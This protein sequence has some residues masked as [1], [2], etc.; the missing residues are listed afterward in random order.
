MIKCKILSIYLIVG[1][2][3]MGFSIL[4]NQPLI[5]SASAA[6]D[7]GIDGYQ[8]LHEDWIVTG[9]EE[10]TDEIIAL[11]GDLTIENGGHLI[12]YNCTLM[13]MSQYL[14]PYEIIVEGGG[15]LE[16]YDGYV[17]D[18]PGDDD[19][20]LLSAYYY[21]VAREGSTLIIEDSTVRQHGFI[22]LAN[23]EHLGLSISTN[24]G[25]ITNSIIN[26][27]VIGLA[28]FGNNSGFYVENSNISQIAMT[29]I[30]LNQAEGVII[31]NISFSETGESNVVDAQSSSNF[32][33]E[34]INLEGEQFIQAEYSFG[35]E[36]RNIVS[37]NPERVLEIN[38]CDNFKVLGVDIVD[39]QDWNRRISVERSTNFTFDDISDND[40]TNVMFFGECSY[41]TISNLTGSNI[42]WMID[43]EK[44]D[45]ITVKDVNVGGNEYVIRFSDSK[46]ITMDR[47]NI[48]GGMFPIYF[49]TVNESSISN[50]IISDFSDAG[51]S[52]RDYSSNVS[53]TDA[54]IETSSI[55]FT[56]GIL[57][58]YGFD[59]YV[60]NLETHNLNI[61]L[62]CRYGSVFAED[63]IIDG[64]LEQKYG[65][66][67]TAVEESLLSNISIINKVQYGF[68]L[69]NC[70]DDTPILNNVYVKDST[71][72][73]YLWRSNISIDKIKI[74]SATDDV[75]ADIG[76][77]ATIMNSTVNSLRLD[78]SDII[79]INTTNTTAATFSGI[80]Q[81]IIK[82]W[83][84]VFVNDKAGPVVGALVYVI[85]GSFMEDAMG[86]TG[87][88]GFVR[89][90]AATEVI[91]TFGPTADNKN[92]HKTEASGPGWLADNLTFYQVDRNMRV[93]V[94]YGGDA[95][96]FEATNIQARSDE[97]SN[98]ILTWDPS[99]SQD[100]IG[101]N[102]YFA[103]NF[104]D[105]W[106]YVDF[107]T[108]NG[109][110]AGTTYTHL[111]G[112]ANWD[113]F[114]Y[115]VLSYDNENMTQFRDV[116]MCGDWVVN[117]SSPQS[118]GNMNINMNGSLIIYGDL[119]LTNINLFFYSDFN[120]FYGIYIHN[121][122]SINIDNLTVDRKFINFPYYF[123]INSDAEVFINNSEFI[124]P[125][126]DEY[127]DDWANIGIYS[128]TK[129]LTITNTKIDVQYAG[130]GIY[131]VLDFQ[132]LIYNVS[133]TT[134]FA[135]EQP[136][137][138][139][140]VMDSDNL[141]IS[142]CS[143]EGTALY[144]IYVGS[145]TNITITQNKIQMHSFNQGPAW[146][147]YFIY[148]G[149]S[150][151]YD[152]PLL[153]GISP[154]YILFS[155]DITV[156]NSNISGHSLYGIHAE[157]SWYTTITECYF[158][159]N[160]RPDIGIYMSWC[161]ESTVRDMESTE[162][163][164]FLIMENE[165][166]AT[167]ENLSITSGDLAITIINSEF[168]LM[169]DVYI[170]FIQN[171]MQIIGGHE[172]TLKNVE[173]NLTLNGLQVKSAGPIYLITSTLANCISGELFAEGYQG[174]ASNLILENSTIA[175]IGDF[176][177]ILNNTAVVHLLNT[178]F[179]LTKLKIED[180][181][182]RLEIFHYLSVQVYDIDNNIPTA[183]D[184]TIMNAKDDIVYDETVLSGYA[185]WILIHEKTVFRDDTYI[186]NPHNIYVF[187][188]SHFG[189]REVYINYSQHI[190]V[191][192][193][194]QFPIITLMGIYGFYDNPFPIPDDFTLFPTTKYD[195][196]LNY[197]YEDPEGDPESGT[198][199]HWYINGIYNSSFDGMTTISPQ[200]TQKG[201]LWQ[202]YV[203]PSDG[204]DSTYPTFAFESNIV[205]ILNTPPSVSNV[206]ITP[207]DPT[208]GDDLFVSFDVFD[209]DDDGLDSSKTTSRWYRYHPING[210]EYS[211]IDSF[212]LPSQYT[213]KGEIWRCIVIPH[214]GDEAGAFALSQNVTIGNTPPS[215]QNA[216]ITAET[217]DV[218]ITGA[219]NLKAQYFFFDSD[220]D[221]ENG[222]AYQWEYQRDGGPWTDVSVN[223][224]VLPFTYTTRGDLW[225]CTIF[226]KDDDDFGDGV[227]TEAMEILNTP[228]MISNV[229]I[230][231]QFATS[232]D[233]LEVIYDYFDYDGDSENGT[234]FRW[235]YEDALGSK[236]SG[237][238][239]NVTPY[240]AVVKQQTW[241]C[242]VIPSDGINVG[243]ELRSDGVLIHNT[244]PTIDEAYMDI[245]ITDIDMHLAINYNA[246]DIDEDVIGSPKIR[247]YKNDDAQ[248][249]FD[250]NQTVPENNL[251]KG[252][253]WYV[254]ISVFDGEDW[255]GNY[256]T[257]STQ[258][259]NTAPFI[260]GTPTLSPSQALSNQNLQPIFED[261]Y[262]DEDGDPLTD[263]EIKWYRDNGHLEDYDDY[264]EISWDL[265]NKGEIWY[266]KV[267]VSDGE[268]SSDWYSSTTTIIKNSP[269]SNITQSP[270]ETEVTI[271]ETETR[272][273]NVS[274][275]DIDRDPLS[276]R[277]TLDGRIVLLDEG[278][279][280]S[281]Y[282][283][284]TD[285]D[286]E[287][288]YI[289]R[290][291]I[292]DGDDSGEITWT[293]N[294]EKMNRL[295]EIAVVEP[296]GRSAS[297]KE[298]EDLRFA[299]TK[300]DSDGDNLDVL[301]YIDGVLVWEGSDKYTYSP[302]YASSGSHT[303]T[304]EVKE[305]E[306]GAN[307]T[308]SWDVEVADVG[309]AMDTFLG[310]N[311][312]L[313]SIMLEII[314]IGGTGLL[315][316]IGYRRIRKKKGALKIYMA[317]IEE[318]SVQKEENPQE[319]EEKLSDIEAKIN[320]E[321]SQGKIEDLHFLMLQE[322]IAGHRGGI[323][324]AAIT[325]KFGGLPEGILKE[326][327]EMLK[328]GK[329]S[330]EEYDG[331][332][333]TI[334]K[335][336]SL[337]SEEK[338][339]L[340]KIIGEW[341]VEDKDLSEEDTPDEKVEPKETKEGKEQD[342][343]SSNEYE[344]E[345]S[346]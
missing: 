55:E 36:V 134:E 72:G 342:V 198:I 132:G 286:S 69:M 269:P 140:S 90:L 50:L 10:Y 30:M 285:Y 62:T 160:D 139:I 303:I 151:I 77:T 26:S 148:C 28:F 9:Y 251:T 29:A 58:D 323:R 91:W 218:I 193:S 82:W 31:N 125:G 278:V 123:K 191:Q 315:A 15:I 14:Q 338:E 52:I 201:Q 252:D 234:S 168:I 68:Y 272:E 96:P 264:D 195:V 120:G 48:A 49:D 65:I 241:Y 226:P 60:R 326:L 21:F 209:L 196:V 93:N 105:L 44:S 266:Y 88:D 79:C 331:F 190:D 18:I 129:N 43:S 154:I 176:S 318:V 333:G 5:D 208:G 66:K 185:K 171:G 84:D 336:K 183:A 75:W 293:V 122:G 89:N 130:L 239:G 17:T 279:E 268:D 200:Y 228:P 302:D 42:T 53:V 199:I 312:D 245:I 311:W 260:N 24:S 219:D 261:L 301:W 41:G 231:P 145:S 51:V 257:V 63:I 215:I 317:E 244:A 267:R 83:V 295:P 166:V 163:N 19:T 113:R 255:S 313:W 288:D 220:G 38:D 56:K 207:S 97:M 35:F 173:I 341:E 109:T 3:L 211:S 4:S 230:Q 118:A 141:T 254:I 78:S 119:Q 32:I 237:I 147:I 149:N 186:D 25:H 7:D 184:I 276:Y 64:T 320:D 214:D 46:H 212:Y 1:M 112:S 283:F 306:S 110:V 314:V 155:F 227:L 81:L 339:E 116:V 92:P 238:H 127:S 277:W 94:T 159:T 59:V 162:V 71:Y 102:I 170:T 213:T 248:S 100:V 296:E 203:Y 309:E 8:E 101:Y 61:S 310:I 242:F 177:F 45:N 249:M 121:T 181:A 340:S 206:T 189:M 235:V 240:G 104:F 143:L 221:L 179:N 246:G 322:I 111:G 265:T 259:P 304:A 344:G 327:D 33:I 274:A 280:N 343:D 282:L 345:L 2:I 16:I 330:R 300:S 156:E 6:P 202:A 137:Y 87:S 73:I 308:Y 114:Y 20:E 188:G 85:D 175:P 290:L 294:V 106:N 115:T 150:R 247:W 40:D 70:I 299:I 210:W 204:Y 74:D 325:R 335:T 172:I 222:S 256:T 205:P 253:S 47:I 321:F 223:S 126:V 57:I 329:I 107:G 307:S 174:E 161:R 243:G 263:F 103:Y 233:S 138:L 197:T 153:K 298:N 271:T 236:E 144:G 165:S 133:F 224:S 99:I 332:V 297:I 167:I 27:T 225:R 67:L 13:M 54:Y 12:L 216:R 292:T 258:I 135:S 124:Q 152:N 334:S 164:Y 346:E 95:P 117:S 187:D 217:G 142:N 182:S 158:D 180:G 305:I 136:E 37:I 39:S 76:C 229:T 275:I 319:Y 232:A 250:D 287:G 11:F 192:V 131:N 270:Q 80:S 324:K 289:L 291:V 262:Q 284:K 169:N 273:F 108:P 22:D 178:P 34:N 328:D 316:F 281:I 128:L 194:N 86:Y 23:P 146:G 157:S 337:S 98:T